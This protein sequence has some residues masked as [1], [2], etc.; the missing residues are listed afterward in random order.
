M[1]IDF[2]KSAYYEFL[3]YFVSEKLNYKITGSCKKCGQCC[4]QIRSKGMRNEKDLKLMQFFLPHYKRFFISGAD[5]DGNI[6]LSCKYLTDEG[7]CGVYDKRPKLCRNYP[8]SSINFNAQMIDGCGFK[9]IKKDFKDY[10]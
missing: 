2:I 3:S 8:N 5:V 4:K 7:L 10:L 1:S 6:I 9:V